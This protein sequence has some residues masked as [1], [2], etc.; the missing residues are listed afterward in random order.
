[1]K[2]ALISVSDKSGIVEFAKKLKELGWELLSTGGTFKLLNESGVDV[3]EVSEITEFP[4]ILDGRV[5]TLHPN[6]HGGILY[7]RDLEEDVKTIEKHG[8]GSIDMVVVN[9]YPFKEAY[10]N[11]SLTMEEKIEQIDIGG[12]SMV[13]AAAKNFKYVNIVVNSEDYERVLEELEGN[14]ETSFET[15]MYLAK[16]AFAHTAR[17]DSMISTYFNEI[18]EDEFPESLIVAYEKESE[19]RYGENP[20]QRAAS[21][22]EYMGEDKG[23]K[24]IKVHQGKELSYNNIGDFNEAVGMIKDFD[25]PTVIAIKHG[26]PCGISS[27]ENVNIAYNKAHD[28]DPQS[29]FG[30]ILISNREVDGNLAKDMNETFLEIVIAPSFTEDALEEFKNKKN[31]RVIGYSGIN[32]SENKSEKTKEQKDRSAESKEKMLKYVEGGLL[33]QDVDS[34]LFGDELKFATKEKPTEKEL[35]DLEFAWKAVKNVKSN[36]IVLA[37]DKTTI[38]IGPGQVSRVW[39]LEN[40]VKQAKEMYGENL[41]GVVL[42]SDGF[43]PFSD[44]VEYANANGIKAVIQP[45]GSKNDS[46]S[47]EVADKY[48][49]KMVLTGIRHFKH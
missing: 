10:Q 32:S 14:G 41:D 16:R 2:R 13:R 43:F 45:G 19:L 34:K 6:V 35:E 49:M 46:D 36:A 20:H 7:R 8:I 22:I 33:I 29:I 48:G 27:D 44:C 15:R 40:A 38:A 21:Y 24:A 31:L 9:L 26:N 3:K 1:M 23:L 18:T 28:A 42:A 39:A 4:E 5:K 11:S 47:V 37:K 17:Y 12:P 25:E 30:G